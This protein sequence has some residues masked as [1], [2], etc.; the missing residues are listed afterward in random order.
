VAIGLLF[1]FLSVEA[2]H[3]AVTVDCTKPGQLL[4]KKLASKKK[5][6]VIVVKGTCRENLLVSRDDVTIKTDGVSS[7]RL[8][9]ADPTRDTIR[10][11]GARRIL[12]DGG[13]A[14]G[15]TV[16]GGLSGIAADRGSTFELK[17]TLVT[18]GSEVGVAVLRGSSGTIDAC[19]VRNN[20]GS[21]IR[22]ASASGTITAST[23]EEN[24]Q[25][26]SS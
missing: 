25:T 17:R 3:A 7:A 16:V 12:I 10:L 1:L 23:V 20:A 13:T 19:Q 11:D 18:G 6:L 2:S 24:G 8:E 5:T 26:G 22:V 4:T 14:G 9:P 15:L 21:G